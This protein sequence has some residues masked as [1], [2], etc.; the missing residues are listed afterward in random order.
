MLDAEQIYNYVSLINTDFNE[1]IESEI[2]M[3]LDALPNDW[4]KYILYLNILNEREAKPI[5]SDLCKTY[6]MF[7]SNSREVVDF[8]NNFYLTNVV[9]LDIALR[10]VMYNLS[11]FL[12]KIEDLK[13]ANEMTILYLKTIYLESEDYEF[14]EIMKEN[15]LI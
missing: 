11:E 15:E 2:Q 4:K 10:Y 9:Y 5:L 6:D 1:N 14:L 3:K 8:K 13:D 7:P 12:E